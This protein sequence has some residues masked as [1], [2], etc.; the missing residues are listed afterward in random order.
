[1]DPTIYDLPGEDVAAGGGFVQQLPVILWQR[2]WWII[3]PAI[4]GLVAAIAAVLLIPPTYRANAIML[5]ESPQLPEEVIGTGADDVI[6][7]RIAAIRQQ[8]TARPDLIELIERHGL[9]TRQRRTSPLSEVIDDMRSSISLVPT[10]AAT[11]SNRPDK[12]TI[13]FELAFEYSEPSQTQAVAQDL[14]D[15]ILQ[16][17]A[18]GNA[19]QATKTVQFLTDQAAGLETQIAALQ[20]QIAEVNARNGGALAGGNMILG[21]NSGSY[22]VQIAALQ[23]D[24][25][26]LLQQRSLAQSSDQRDPVVVAAEQRLAGARSIYAE[27]HPDVVLAK[28]ALAEA[29]K[30]AKDNSQK[31]PLQTIDEQIAFNNSQISALRAAKG[32][33]MAQ[34]NSRLSQQARVPLVQQQ[35]SEL[36]QRLT[37]LNAQ[38]EQV[39]NRL[40]SAQAG[41]RAEDEQMAERLSVVEP[42]IIPDE[43]SWPNRLLLAAL[44][45]GGGIGLGL[46]L[47]LAVELFMRPIRDPAALKGLLGASPLG[48]IPMIEIPDLPRSGWRKWLPDRWKSTS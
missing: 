32:Q 9:Y 31:L 7:R 35:L 43:P 29:R 47:A 23:R 25:Q 42:P 34:I 36:Q 21:G 45:I 14:M 33:E 46:V 44:G 41:V 22:D 17:D 1:M 16:L 13:A 24:N 8:I 19:E 6:D 20:S 15:R 18:R 4:I 3:G 11:A 48:V 38:Y 12:Q 10:E 27:S 40:L 2:K 39:Q 26:V 30:L 37:A 28:Q 5:V